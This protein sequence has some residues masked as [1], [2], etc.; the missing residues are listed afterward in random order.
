MRGGR[1]TGEGGLRGQPR[2]PSSLPWLAPR[3]QPLWRKAGVWVSGAGL[4]AACAAG[5]FVGGVNSQR[6]LSAPVVRAGAST[7][8][9]ATPSVAATT[10]PVAGETASNTVSAP[11]TTSEGAADSTGVYYGDAWFSGLESQ[12]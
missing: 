5:V 12:G 3:P 9:T 2:T 10:V 7:T 4:A 11:A 1:G 6:L 8:A